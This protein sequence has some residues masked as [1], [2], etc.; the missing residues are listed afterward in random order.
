MEDENARKI[1]SAGAGRRGSAPAP[2][3]ASQM[4]GRLLKDDNGARDETTR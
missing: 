4:K 2:H 1:V 3:A